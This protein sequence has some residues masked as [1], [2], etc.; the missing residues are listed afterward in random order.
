MS[1]ISCIPLQEPSLKLKADS[2]EPRPC[3]G[4]ADTRALPLIWTN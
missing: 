1:G 4:E 3:T 2:G